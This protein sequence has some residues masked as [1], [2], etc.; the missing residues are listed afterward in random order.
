MK[1]ERALKCAAAV[2]LLSTAIR[3]A[4][5]LAVLQASASG[6]APGKQLELWLKHEFYQRVDRRSAAF[7]QMLKSEAAG[8][9]WQADRKAFFLQQL[10]GWPERTPL[11]AQVVGRLAGKGCRLEKILF[12]SRPGHHVTANLYLPESAGPWPAVIVPCGHSHDGK[13]AVGYQQVGMLLA[14]HGMAAMCYD[15]IGQ[16]ERYQM[17]DLGREH[18]TFD[19]AARVKVPHPNVHVLCTTEHTMMGIGSILLGTNIAQYRIWDGMRAIDYLQ[20]RP[21][22]RGDKIGCTGNSGGGTLTAYLM[23]L[24]DRI[25]A[26]APVCY[27]TTFRRLI[28]SNGAQD[29]EQ[30]I[31]GQIDFGLDEADFCLMRAPRP[32]LICA[33]TRDA[34]FDFR[35]TWEVFLEAKRFYSRLGRSECIEINAPDAPHGFTLQQREA[36]VRWMHRWL[37]GSDQ[38]IREVESLPDS[39][40]DAQLRAMGQ[41]E[42][43]Q[44]QL[45]C[46]P[47]GQ[48][49]LMPGERSVFQ[50]N[51]G[52]VAA[53]SVKR[54]TVWR[55]LSAEARRELVRKTIGAGSPGAATPAKVETVATF[56]RRGY[57]VRKLALTVDERLVLPALAFIPAK[58]RG[59]ATLYLH[60]TSMAADAAPG[61]RIEQLVNQGHIVLAAE[62]RGIGETET[63]HDKRD[64]GYG[65]F[66]RDN[67]EIFLA[68]LIGKSFVGMRVDDVLAWA[69][70]LRSGAL[71][72]SAPTAIQLE[73]VGEAAIPALHAAAL[74]NVEYAAVKLSRMITSWESVVSATETFDQAVNMVHGALQHYDLGDLVNLAGREKVRIEHPVDPMGKPLGP[75]E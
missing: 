29:A 56:E 65:S 57:A 51:A 66:G 42:W 68:Y 59:P 18:T 45:Y 58:P 53:L 17:L 20:S 8:R 3:A 36:A 52:I 50:I 62:L 22:I 26:A 21:D 67:Q 47:R 40:T 19:G 46:S 27:L 31:F 37:L 24:D 64:Y 75:G 74:G 41:G 33:G 44:E 72:G 71:T 70:F 1:T 6:V 10:G 60:G 4:D 23:A 15:P 14:R 48:V 9:K 69:Q 2:L 11:N 16:G 25:V 5:D 28:D 54:A 63:G 34:T 13:A 35:G 43:T 39:F 49:M 73:A 30:N 38:L 61:G 32:T 55:G 7:E 12:E